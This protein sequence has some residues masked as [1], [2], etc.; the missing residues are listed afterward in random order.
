MRLEYLDER[1]VFLVVAKTR[2]ETAGVAIGHT[3]LE[4]DEAAAL[5]L[6]PSLRSCDKGPPY[7]AAL[8]LLGHDKFSDVGLLLAC[9]MALTVDAYET[10]A[11][12]LSILGDEHSL[13]RSDSGKGPFDPTTRRSQKGSR[14]APWRTADSETW[15]EA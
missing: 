13:V 14:I 7:A 6:P 12:P 11:P 8:C 2:V 9:E 5:L 15:G 10:H 4:C 1:H 3:G